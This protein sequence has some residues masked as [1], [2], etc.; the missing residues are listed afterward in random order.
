VLPLAV[1]VSPVAVIVPRRCVAHRLRFAAS[2]CRPSP[3]SCH[4]SPCCPLSSLCCEHASNPPKRQACSPRN[5]LG[6]IA[7][8]I[9]CN[10]RIVLSLPSVAWGRCL[11]R[12]IRG[13]NPPPMHL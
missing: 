9:L 2:S 10:H 7:R 5:I 6:R 3:P 8:I 4:L 12:C 11:I 1:V 13:R